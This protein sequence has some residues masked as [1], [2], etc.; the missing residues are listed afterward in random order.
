MERLKISK[1]IASEDVQTIIDALRYTDIDQMVSDLER[2]KSQL[3]DNDPDWAD[4]WDG[5]ILGC[6]PWGIGGMERAISKFQDLGYAEV[7][8][9]EETA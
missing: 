9:D 1:A 8:T 4:T 7:E 6:D 3:D 5:T 2:L